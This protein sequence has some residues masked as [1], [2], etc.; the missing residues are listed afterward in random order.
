[1]EAKYTINEVDGIINILL[2]GRLDATNAPA[3]MEDLKQFIGKPIKEI[4]FI[5]KDLDYIASAGLRTMIFAKQKINPEADI[6]LAGA[7]EEVLEVIKMS[8]LDNF[9]TIK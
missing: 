7:K 8:G 5:A 6:S 4:A 3:L 9:L 2:E 1:M